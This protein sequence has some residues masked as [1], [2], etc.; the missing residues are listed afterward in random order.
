MCCIFLITMYT[1]IINI[2]IIFFLLTHKNK[3]SDKEISLKK[4]VVMMMIIIIIQFLITFIIKV[5]WVVPV[6]VM[7]Q[8]SNNKASVDSAKVKLTISLVHVFEEKKKWSEIC[9]HQKVER[10]S[11][12]NEYCRIKKVRLWKLHDTTLSCHPTA[13]EKSQYGINIYN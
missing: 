3:R 10:L 5:I 1:F 6:S 9:E 8:Y 13:L 7:T 4:W 11:K 2:V 12:K